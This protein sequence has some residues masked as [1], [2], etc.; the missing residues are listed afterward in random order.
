MSR[1]VTLRQCRDC[2]GDLVRDLY[3]DDMWRQHWSSSRYKRYELVTAVLL[4]IQFFWDIM[5]RIDWCIVADI[6][7]SSSALV[8]GIKQS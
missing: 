1:R 8:S 4:R 2:R 7:R 6:L 5:R 3:G